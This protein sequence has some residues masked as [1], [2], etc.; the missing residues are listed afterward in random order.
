M[1]DRLDYGE[2]YTIDY[3]KNS[4]NVNAKSLD[5]LFNFTLDLTKTAQDSGIVN[6][7]AS[8]VSPVVKVVYKAL[9]NSGDAMLTT[10][11][12]DNY[13]SKGAVYYSGV[14][15][16]VT[17]GTENYVIDPILCTGKVLKLPIDIPCSAGFA[18]VR[19]YEGTDYA[20]STALSLFNR[21][22]EEGDNAK[23]LFGLS[24]VA[25]TTK[26]T[27]LPPLMFGVEGTNQ[28]AGGGGGSGSNP[29][30]L[31]TT[32]KYLLEITYSANCTVTGRLEIVEV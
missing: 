18:V 13:I 7:G 29:I 11:Y 28:S 2:F 30:I 12:L 8:D 27:E 25:G 16:I 4:G 6:N 22:R 14:S 19:L 3:L 21:N 31:D 23:T 5:F 17:A 15:K 26:G 24:T 20:I 10:G 9:S 32:K 1:T